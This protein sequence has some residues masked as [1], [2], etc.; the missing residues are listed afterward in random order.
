M[1]KYSTV[2]IPRGLGRV[3]EVFASGFIVRIH[4]VADV[5]VYLCDEWRLVS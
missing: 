5:T 4:N 2:M 3:V 1:K